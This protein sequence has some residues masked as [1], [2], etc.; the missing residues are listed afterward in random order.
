M[1]G[2]GILAL[3]RIGSRLAVAC[4]LVCFLAFG[5]AHGFWLAK[6]VMST[7]TAPRHFSFSCLSVQRKEH[8]SC[9]LDFCCFGILGKEKSARVGL[10]SR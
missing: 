2:V 1:T 8:A 10:G 4:L 5:L 7:G 6:G 3:T 9:F